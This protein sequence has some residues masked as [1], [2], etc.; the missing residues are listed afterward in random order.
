MKALL[1]LLFIQASISW[2]QDLHQAFSQEVCDPQKDSLRAAVIDPAL[3]KLA[4]QEKELK[5]VSF[6]SVA[7]KVNMTE[8]EYRLSPEQKLNPGECAY[9]SV[10]TELQDKPLFFVILGHRQ[11]PQEDTG[12][13]PG[14]KYDNNP[15]LT[16]LQVNE[17]NKRNEPRWRFWGG[18]ASGSLGAKFAEPGYSLE[19][20]GLYEWYD[21]GHGDIQTG[22][23]KTSPL[24]AD[25]IR[26]CS[27][28]K[29]P[30]RVGSLKLKVFPGYAKDYQE[31]NFG[32]GNAM[33]DSFT[34][35]GREYGE[36]KG[37][38]VLNGTNKSKMPKGWTLNGSQL[39]IPLPKGKSLKSLEASVSDTHAPDL[40]Q[41]DDGDQTTSGWG[42]FSA[43][44]QKKDGSRVPLIQSEN[45]PPRGV[46][47]GS[48]EKLSLTEN[49]DVL[50]I[51]GTSDKIYLLGMKI[52]LD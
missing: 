12:R 3:K 19:I 32:Q 9:F 7:D 2:S 29:D 31:Y 18:S 25:A 24:K 22:E 39:S 51:E 1:S 42:R 30:V 4:D 6:R 27:S 45:V 8:V 44:I 48:P 28:G 50:I 46:I 40:S 21:H 52:G 20:E 38:I 11:D 10:P 13:T 23:M 43:Y 17:L 49:G 16:T 26:L 14:E 35:K 36:L 33:G 41:H 15:G 5:V 37:A 34:A 47:T